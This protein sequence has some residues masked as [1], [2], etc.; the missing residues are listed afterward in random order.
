M[1]GQT[2][3]LTDTKLILEDDTFRTREEYDIKWEFIE[4]SS[5]ITFNYTGKNIYYGYNIEQNGQK[6][7]L[8]LYGEAFINLYNQKN[9]LVYSIFGYKYTMMLDFNV[10][11][12]SELKENNVMYKAENIVNTLNLTPWVEGSQND[13]VNEKITYIPKYDLT[14]AG[15]IIIIANGFV[16]YN[17]P[18]LYYYNNRVKKIRIKNIGYNEYQD[19]DLEDTPHYQDF[20][21]KFQEISKEIE[22]EIL[23]VYRGTRYNDTCINLMLP[24]GF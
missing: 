12:S 24:G 20:N 23:E 11:A 10:R 21:I 3:K 2:A 22:I 19:I 13:G 6:K 8:V 4:K 9:E 16:G 7:Y 1:Y 5:Y 17:R 15:I 14:T 18:H